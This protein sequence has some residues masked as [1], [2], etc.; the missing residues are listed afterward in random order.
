MWRDFAIICYMAVLSERLLVPHLVKECEN[1]DSSGLEAMAKR[2]DS[3]IPCVRISELTLG[4]RRRFHT[5]NLIHVQETQRYQWI[6][7]Y[8]KWAR[9]VRYICLLTQAQKCSFLQFH[10]LESS[11]RNRSRF[12]RVNLIRL[13]FAYSGCKGSIIMENVLNELDL[14][15][16]LVSWS[17]S[18]KKIV[19]QFRVLGRE[20]TLRLRS[21]YN[22]ELDSAQ[23]HA[24][25][26]LLFKTT[27]TDYYYY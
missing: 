10:L 18:A 4:F 11:L 20:S 15:V 8:G 13:K 27:R 5:V 23:I 9:L 16:T 21:R 17:S 6:I 19:I 12:T 24:Q 2:I 26:T 25:K 3:P 1:A 14:L 7:I 22:S